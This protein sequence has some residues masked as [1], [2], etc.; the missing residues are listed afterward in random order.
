MRL[1]ITEQILLTAVWSLQD[2]AYGIKIMERV[3]E[4]IKKEI[5]FGTLYN[6]LDQLI[7]KGYAESFKGEPTAVRGGKRKVYYKI[8]TKGIHALQEARELQR[9]LRQD[10]PNIAVDRSK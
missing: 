10:M 6:N 7:K 4:Y 9:R 3:Y 1:T 8:T 5:A 2:E